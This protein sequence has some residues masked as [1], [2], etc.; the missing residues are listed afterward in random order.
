MEKGPVKQLYAAAL[1]TMTL[2]VAACSGSGAVVDTN[3]PGG[4][5]ASTPG[6]PPSTTVSVTPLSLTG[7]PPTSVIA[8]ATYSFKP[9]VSS[10]AA[11]VTFFIQA[12]PAWANFNAD[13][14]ALSGTP[15]DGNVGTTP[16]IVITASNGSS[17]ASLQPFAITVDAP[18][19]APPGTGNGTGTATLTWTA[20]TENTDGTALTDLAGYHIYYGTSAEA[21]TQEVDV[22]GAVTTT[23]EISGLSSGTYYFA[24]TAYSSIGIES[25]E[26]NVGSKT[27]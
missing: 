5:P 12:K 11:P 27:I 6:T 26:S 10:G 8:G 22:P 1:L 19:S 13:T 9:I 3:T 4:A 20:P 7:S 18:P 25:A 14:G 17:S 21:L 2:A 15:A 16:N 23:Y 24:V